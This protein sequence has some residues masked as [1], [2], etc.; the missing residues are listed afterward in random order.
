MTE[1]AYGGGAPALRDLLGGN[2]QVFLDGIT[3]TAPHA[4][5]PNI[6]I[7]A[8]TTENRSPLMPD[9]PTFKEQRYRGA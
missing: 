5:S 2:I 1:V 7:L 4:T 9:V 8:V 6:R 3:T